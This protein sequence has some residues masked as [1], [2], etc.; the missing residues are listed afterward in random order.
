LLFDGEV[1]K[2]E[3]KLIEEWQPRFHAMCDGLDAQSD[4]NEVGRAGQTL[5]HWVE[6]EAR[7]PFRTVSH[8]F[9]SVGSFNM[10]A[11]EVRVGWHRAYAE[12]FTTA[13]VSLDGNGD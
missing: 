8:R 7:F 13:M 1:G 4:P 10:L 5:Y 3:Q 6:A 2:F 12:T 9:L 11:E